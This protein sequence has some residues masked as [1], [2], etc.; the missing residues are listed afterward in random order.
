MDYQPK[1]FGGST[2]CN[3][4]NPNIKHFSQGSQGPGGVNGGHIV[5][6]N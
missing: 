3:F 5:T 4:D 6:L 2:A 1:V